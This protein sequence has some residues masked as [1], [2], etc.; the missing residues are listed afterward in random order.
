MPNW[1]DTAGRREGVIY[2]R[3]NMAERIPAAPVVRR[4]KLTELSSL[5]PADT[6]TVSAA[7]RA[8]VLRQRAE[9]V[10]RRLAL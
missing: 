2:Y 8:E 4:V 5:L 7:E 9:D 6:P 10:A 1:L 3:W